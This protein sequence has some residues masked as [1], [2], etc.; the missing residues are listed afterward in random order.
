MTQPTGACMVRHQARTHRTKRGYETDIVVKCPRCAS[1]SRLSRASIP[2]ID[3]CGFESYSFRCDRCESAVGGVIDP[4]DGKLLV[5][6]LEPTIDK[7]AVPT[8]TSITRTRTLDPL[9]K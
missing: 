4:L 3:T 5:S 7:T 2:H 1:P 9:I 6:L 8:A